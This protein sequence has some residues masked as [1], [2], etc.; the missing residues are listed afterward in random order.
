MS[1]HFLYSPLASCNHS[2]EKL[3]QF[4]TL[5]DQHLNWLGKKVPRSQ[6][7]HWVLSY[8]GAKNPKILRT[9]TVQLFQ[10]SKEIRRK[11]FKSTLIIMKDCYTMKNNSPFSYRRLAVPQISNQRAWLSSHVTQE[12][13]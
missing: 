1:M 3:V 2:T 5:S 11:S 7:H 9:I 10:V 13:L 8:G 4:T 12:T 6:K